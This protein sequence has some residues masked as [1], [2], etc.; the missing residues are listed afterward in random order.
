MTDARN[1]RMSDVKFA[2]TTTIIATLWTA[3]IVGAGV[4][5]VEFSD[6]FA[7]LF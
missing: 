2:R 6:V 5:L 1:P 7:G 3:I 4:A